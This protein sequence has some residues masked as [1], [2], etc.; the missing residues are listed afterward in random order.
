[1]WGGVDA[2]LEAASG[3]KVPGNALALMSCVW[4]GGIAKAL[5]PFSIEQHL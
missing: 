4:G 3:R 5:L 2:A 1:M